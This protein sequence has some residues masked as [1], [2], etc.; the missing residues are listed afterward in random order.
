M[1]RKLEA[2]LLLDADLSGEGLVAAL[3]AT[4]ATEYVLLERG[5]TVFGVLT[6]KDVDAAYAAA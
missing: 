6:T 2:G 5:G 4:L 3:Q 1:A